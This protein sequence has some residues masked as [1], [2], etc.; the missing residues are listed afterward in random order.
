[1][2]VRGRAT[3]RVPLGSALRVA[4]ATL[5]GWVIAV[6]SALAFGV[7]EGGALPSGPDVQGFFGASLIGV[8]LLAPLVWLPGLLRLRQR[9]NRAEPWLFAL[10][11]ATLLNLPLFLLLALGAARGAFAPGEAT[12]F[13]AIFAAVG[14]IFGRSLARALD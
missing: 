2:S 14:A 12:M 5:G 10:V 7:L 13:G 9:R 8:A 3:A 1:V 4:L 6:S 11:A